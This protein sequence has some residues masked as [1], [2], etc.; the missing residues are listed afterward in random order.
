MINQGATLLEKKKDV[1]LR[2]G[3]YMYCPIVGNIFFVISEAQAMPRLILLA[4]RSGYT[5]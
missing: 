4:Y 3:V 2:V 5:S 1:W